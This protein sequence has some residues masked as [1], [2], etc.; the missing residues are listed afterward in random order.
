MKELD[1]PNAGILFDF[2][3]FDRCGRYGG[4]TKSLPFAPAVCAK[5]LKF[6]DKGNDTRTDYF[7]ILKVVYDSEFSGVISIEFE[8][9]GI[10]PTEGALMTKKLNLKALEAARK[11]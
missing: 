7:R 2:T 11:G 1:R 5:V 9:E 8:V 6:G 10:D 4:V 3:N